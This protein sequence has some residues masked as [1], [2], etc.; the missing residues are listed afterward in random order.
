[1][2][3][4]LRDSRGFTLPELI[5]G[6]FFGLI[7]IGTLYGFYREQLFN[8]LAQ[9]TKTGTLQDGR[10]ALDLM[11]RELRNAG[12]WAG[13]SAPA[14]CSRVVA[15]TST[16]IRIQADLDGNG[17]CTSSTGE[18]V[19]YSLAGATATCPGS[20]IRRNGDCLIPNIVI[21]SGRAFL[22][23]YGAGSKNPLALP[24]SDPSVLKRVKITFTVQVKNPDPKI[25][26]MLTSD[27]SSS[28]ELRN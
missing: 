8:L 10:G 16:T 9:E 12:G 26:G 7:I 28:V 20:T 18:D 23:Y 17:D 22:T 1:M 5:M 11:V 24:I 4:G 3:R 2:K 14:G 27:L 15:A 25:G 19:T 21:P 6:A 13:G